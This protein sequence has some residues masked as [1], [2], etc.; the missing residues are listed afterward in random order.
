MFTDRLFGGEYTLDP[1]QNCEF[2]CSYCDSSYEKTVF[3]KT[4][5]VEILKR[6]L[7]K[8]K[9]G[10]VIL[11]SVHDPY[12]PIEE[13]TW[14]TRELLEV[15]KEYDMPIHILTKSPLILRDLDI[16]TSLSDVLVTFTIITTDQRLSNIFEKNVPT[17]LKRFQT[18]KEL[19][20]NTIK[21]GIAL[22][23]ILPYITEKNAED[24]VE[25]ASLNKVDYIIYKHL[26]LKGYQKGVMLSLLNEVDSNLIIK[27]K[28]LYHNRYYPSEEYVHNTN[29]RIEIICKRY[30]IQT[31][32]T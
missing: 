8:I 28:R 14:L 21:A 22:I 24:L 4:N 10:R 17:P 27:Y 6:E 13:K 5:A 9:K 31:F 19:K 18:I 3:I 11:G 23:P 32:G 16:L 25:K 1:Y 15:I 2:G 12:Q 7:K 29:K 20:N 30:G 26:E